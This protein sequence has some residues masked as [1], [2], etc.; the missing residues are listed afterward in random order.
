M[1]DAP[2]D[3]DIWE[4]LYS[5]YA[6]DVPF[7][8][9]SEMMDK[10]KDISS[11]ENEL[12]KEFEAIL[13][14]RDDDWGENLYWTMVILAK[15]GSKKSIPLF[16]R[17]L[18]QYPDYDYV[19]EA[20]HQCLIWLGE[21]AAREAMAWMKEKRSFVEKLYVSGAFEGV[22]DYGDE[23]LLA[24]VKK[25]L[26][27]RVKLEESIEDDEECLSQ[28]LMALAYFPGEDVL[29]F[30]RSVVGRYE[31]NAD[32]NAAFEAAEGRFPIERR[33]EYSRDWREFCELY[34]QR[35]DPEREKKDKSHKKHIENLSQENKN[36]WKAEDWNKV[37]EVGKELKKEAFLRPKVSP[38]MCSAHLNLKM[39]KEFEAEAREALALISERWELFPD[40]VDYKKEIEAF[41][42]LRSTCEF[43][44][45]DDR[46]FLISRF[47]DYMDGF[48]RDIGCAEYAV[49]I[50]K[51]KKMVNS[52][53]AVSDGLLR[54]FFEADE[55][56][57]ILQD[58]YIALKAV[59]DLDLLIKECEKRKLAPVYPDS[60]TRV[61]LMQ[62]G[63]KYELYTKEEMALDQ[64]IRIFTLGCWNLELFRIKMRNDIAGFANRDQLIDKMR[65]YFENFPRL[66]DCVFKA[67]NISPRWELG[68]R[69]PRD[70]KIN[71]G[72]SMAPQADKAVKTGRNA[73]CPCGSGKKYKKCCGR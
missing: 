47:G 68:G 31:Y 55:E 52:P 7:D 13:D 69:A 49:A 66:A 3:D 6:P 73:L 27:D 16:F 4:A 58:K 12:I 19:L 53:D 21:P 1:S 46:L 71:D 42:I 36:A 59:E 26:K 28:F 2:I 20:V 24:D 29:P 34:A 57:F 17:C 72:V 5:T 30:V 70:L 15:G 67:W 62:E 43:V 8:A 9:M 41:E 44:S 18:T 14:D 23:A 35:L 45:E 40:D 48:L 38:V 25:F 51:I 56:V 11:V 63:R 22:L 10:C 33:N 61:K 32:L 37:I 65:V 39:K 60:L 50:K 64:E 54:K